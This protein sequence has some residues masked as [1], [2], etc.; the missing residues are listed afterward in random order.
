MWTAPVS[1]TFKSPMRPAVA[2]NG[3]FMTT[4]VGLM[5][6]GSTLL[7]CSA[8]SRVTPSSPSDSSIS[9]RLSLIS[10][11]HTLSAPAFLAWTA[12]PPVPAEGSSTRSPSPM[13][14]TQ[15]AAKA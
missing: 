12:M 13:F 1:S 10:L 6:S 9:A 11:P 5:P 3:G 8:F 15:L 7:S 4:T 14:A 2:E